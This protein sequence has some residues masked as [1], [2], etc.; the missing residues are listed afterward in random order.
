M[1]IQARKAILMT[2]TGLMKFAGTGMKDS[3]FLIV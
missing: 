1:A 3:H 2:M